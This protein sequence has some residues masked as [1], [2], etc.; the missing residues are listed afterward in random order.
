MP[1]KTHEDFPRVYSVNAASLAKPHALQHFASELSS[2]S[3]DVAIIS[4]THFK[5]H[6]STQMTQLDGYTCE[7]RDRVGRRGGGVAI[8]IKNGFN[9]TIRQVVGDGDEYETLWLD[10]RW[11]SLSLTCAALHH[12]PRPIYNVEQFKQFL[13]SNIDDVCLSTNAVF[14]IAGDFNQLS[15]SEICANTGLLSLVKTATRGQS[16][17]DRV[18]TNCM[19]TLIIKVVTSIIKTDHKAVILSCDNFSVSNYRNKKTVQFIIKSPKQNAS[20]LNALQVLDFSAVYCTTD[21][22]ECYNAFTSI[23]VGLLD[24]HFPVKSITISDRD[25]P[26]I[27]PEIKSLLRKKN[28]LMRN[29]VTWNRPTHWQIKSK[30]LLLGKTQAGC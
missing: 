17:L 12:H 28:E 25:P 16:C 23:I 4:E 6:H 26:F 22:T 29:A 9:Y 3:A 19:S 21:V 18:Y 7:R 30:L 20:L 15:D 8:Y 11:R 24:Q 27:T 13:F 2:F 14:L 1:P 10:L 5:K